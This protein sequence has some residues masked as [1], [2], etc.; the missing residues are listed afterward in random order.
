MS[1]GSHGGTES[2]TST[3]RTEG[4][5]PTLSGTEAMLEVIF[6]TVFEVILGE[7]TILV[8]SRAEEGRGLMVSLES[9]I[10]RGI[11]AVPYRN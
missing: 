5:C 6:E 11:I 3:S 8:H 9:S 10:Y 7:V 2:F 4:P 1:L